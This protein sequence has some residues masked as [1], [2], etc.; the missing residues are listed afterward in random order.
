[1]AAVP[2]DVAE[3]AFTRCLHDIRACRECKGALAHEPRPVVLADRRARVLIVGQAPGRIVHETGIP[4]NDRSGDRLRQWLQIPYDDFYADKRIAVVPMGFCFPG[5][6]ANGDLPPRPEC[7][8][9]WHRLLLTAMPEVKLALLVGT[10]AQRYYLDVPRDWSLTDV[11]RNG[12]AG[13]AG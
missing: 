2:D 6:G 1:M 7:A 4:W 12:P 10:Y 8:P 9:K 11:V 13:G 5:T 3:A